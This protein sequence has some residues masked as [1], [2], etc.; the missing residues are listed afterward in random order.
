M[1]PFG[2]RK[3]KYSV[4]VG[5][6]FNEKFDEL[7]EKLSK[8]YSFVGER[9]SRFLEWRFHQSPYHEYKVF[10]LVSSGNTSVLGYVIF[11]VDGEK[12]KIADIGFDGTEESFTELLSSFSLH[13][14]ARGIES[15]SLTIA[16]HPKLI[17]LLEQLGYSLRS[18]ERKVLI[19]A[20]ANLKS[21][22]ESVKT[23]QWFLTSADND[24]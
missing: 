2:T 16:G 5:T 11:C 20:P 14:R 7:W 22:L 23:D 6:G 15:I 17:H 12:A 1:A 19:Y 3:R 4:E 9:S 8:K 10:S 13:Q 21:I 18:R 24:I